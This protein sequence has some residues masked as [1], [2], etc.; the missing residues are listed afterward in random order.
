MGHD[1]LESIANE[2]VSPDMLLAVARLQV[3]AQILATKMKEV[4]EADSIDSDTQY[5][6]NQIE[7]IFT[8]PTLND[9]QS[10][11]WPLLYIMRYIVRKF[12]I[13]TL[14]KFSDDENYSWIIPNELITVQVYYEISYFYS[15]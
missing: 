4:T 11:N 5:F 8:S 6:C 3:S 1:T 10:S 9:S 12:G 7:K 14:L 2:P 15:I 13:S